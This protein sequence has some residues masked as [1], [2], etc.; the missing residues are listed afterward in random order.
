MRWRLKLSG[1]AVYEPSYTRNVYISE[2]STIKVSERMAINIHNQNQVKNSNTGDIFNMNDAF[3]GAETDDESV[4]KIIRQKWGALT[5]FSRIS[6]ANRISISLP[7]GIN[8]KY[9]TF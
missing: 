6:G 4:A 7:Q 8:T 1:D 9:N 5:T 2:G 3:Q